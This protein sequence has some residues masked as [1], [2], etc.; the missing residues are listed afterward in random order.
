MGN[1]KSRAYLGLRWPLWLEWCGHSFLPVLCVSRNSGLPNCQASQ[2][3]PL[4]P[5]KPRDRCNFPVHHSLRVLLLQFP[6]E[7]RCYCFGKLRGHTNKLVLC[8]SAFV[9][10]SYSS[11]SRPF[12]QDC[13]EARHG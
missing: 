2:R 5:C 9:A 11:A 7:V 4:V 13:S 6:P 1:C 8:T 12:G 10:G 3:I